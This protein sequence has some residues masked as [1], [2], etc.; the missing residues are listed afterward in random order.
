[1]SELKI[2]DRGNRGQSNA[3]MST[4]EVGKRKGTDFLLEPLKGMEHS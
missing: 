4:L 2:C 1:M 3:S